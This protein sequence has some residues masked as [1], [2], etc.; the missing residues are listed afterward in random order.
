[1]G[2]AVAL[3]MALRNPERVSHLGLVDF[4]PGMRLTRKARIP[5]TILPLARHLPATVLASWVHGVLL[6]VYDD[7]DRGAR[8]L[9]MYLRPFTTTEGRAALL[10]HLQSADRGANGME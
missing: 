3:S 10:S 6:R 8:S 5:R 2:G 4:V 9:D 7:R 1:M